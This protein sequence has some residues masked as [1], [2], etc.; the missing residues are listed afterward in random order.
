M[1]V[2]VDGA[3]VVVGAAVVAGTEDV[4]DEVVD[5]AAATVVETGSSPPASPLATVA[6]S[7]AV[8]V[9]APAR[10]ERTT[11]ATIA[12]GLRAG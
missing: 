2:V 9:H 3:A 11:M 12:S 4:V 7:S 6:G 10:V 1:V 8:S 5:G